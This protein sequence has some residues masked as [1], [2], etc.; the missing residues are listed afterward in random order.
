MSLGKSAGYER[1]EAEAVLRCDSHPMCCAPIASWRSSN[2][3][4]HGRT[5]IILVHS[6]EIDVSPSC[7]LLAFVTKKIRSGR[8][9]AS[10]ICYT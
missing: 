10:F 9:P 3:P 7:V 5:K 4:V 1:R 8:S 6:G 2:Q